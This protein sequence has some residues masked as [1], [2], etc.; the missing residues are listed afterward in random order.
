MLRLY[1]LFVLTIIH[2]LIVACKKEIQASM[3]ICDIIYWLDRLQPDSPTISSTAP[4][5]KI[6]TIDSLI[7]RREKQD[8][9]KRAWLNMAN[10]GDCSD[11]FNKTER[12]GYRLPY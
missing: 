8:S 2:F 3:D 1:T 4:A 12:I 5:I 11:N 10:I 6:P 9:Q 7:R